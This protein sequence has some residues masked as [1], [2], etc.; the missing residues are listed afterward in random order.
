MTEMAPAVGLLFDDTELGGQLREALQDRGARIVHE[1]GVSSLTREVLQ[2][3]GVDVLV[4]NLDDS[5]DDALDQLYDVVDGSHPRVVFNDAQASRSL[6]GWDRARW[7]RH[8]AVKV[9]AAG[10]V[11]PP[12]P[13]DS[14]EVAAPVAVAVVAAAVA[15][16]PSLDSAPPVAFD[17]P[18]AVFDQP[19]AE[20]EPVVDDVPDA[21]IDNDI[22]PLDDDI[23][24]DQQGNAASAESENLA[25][26]L[27]ALLA[28]GEL[29]QEE[30]LPGPG[31]RFVDGIEPPPLH[32]GN[33]G[34]AEIETPHTGADVPVPATPS[35]ALASAS[36][37]E[38]ANESLELAALAE[39]DSVKVPDAAPQAA[40]PDNAMP[41]SAPAGWALL[42]DD[43]PPADPPP[44]EKPH[45]SEFGIEKMSAADFL[46]HDV[47]AVAADLEPVMSLELVSME[48][49]IAPKPY[50]HD[51]EMVL[52]E[53][54]SALSR[55][56]LLGAGADGVES[57]LAFLAALPASTRLAI[58]HT[59]RADAA[60]LDLLAQRFREHCALPVRMA[61]QGGRAG[62]GE[63]L[64]IPAGQQLRL[65]RDGK[66]EL[67]AATDVAADGPTIDASLTMAANAFG[68]DALA[69]VFCG[70]GN[71][72]VA[73]AQ[74]IHDRGGQ[75]W[76][77]SS[78]GEH[79]GDMVSG[80]LAERLVSFS[81]T[82]TE[83][84][85]RL[86]E[87]FP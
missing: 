59:Q 15:V 66:V 22:S 56:V 67:Q 73:G 36:S 87:V 45:A 10:D 69:I 48:E 40:R 61:E 43:A 72:A 19:A 11:D 44:E 35:A 42:D 18:V 85:A 33:F 77:E 62:H 34:A 46:A 1:G 21:G 52:D 3:T 82:P 70:R 32:D 9:L 39:T 57:V 7:A 41:I 38:S 80:I 29:P 74:A 6:D 16:P 17:D 63:V 27:E 26:E 2:Q 79:S 47:D 25:A 86:I 83:L 55:V 60:A 49:A 54:G 8:L 23:G 5:A 53:L 14:R 76:V 65:R 71:D 81:G 37:P 84:A 68:R 12:R 31:L 75:V 58:V 24:D 51:H 64:L 28:S 4:V 13:T 50:V 20:A 78:N 30:E